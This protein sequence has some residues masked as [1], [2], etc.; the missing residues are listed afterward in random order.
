[1]AVALAGAAAGEAPLAGLA[2]GAPPT[3][4]SVSAPALACGGVALLLQGALRVAVAGCKR[5]H[6]SALKTQ[7]WGAASHSI[8]TG[9]SNRCHKGTNKNP[10]P[11]LCSKQTA[12]HQTEPFQQLV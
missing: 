1:M 4:G 2:V 10:Q 9:V 11:G 7:P 3:H 5:G 8:C 6:L 12:A